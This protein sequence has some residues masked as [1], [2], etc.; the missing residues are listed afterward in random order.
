MGCH[1]KEKRPEENDIYIFFHKMEKDVDLNYTIEDYDKNYDQISKLSKNKFKK[2]EK[3]QSVRI[4]FVNEIM[5]N[6]SKLDISEREDR[7]TRK[8]LFY[9]LVLTMTLNNFLK[10]NEYNSYIKSN[11]D[12]QQS[13]L[14]L[15][16]QT[17]EQ[18]F[19]NIQNLKLIIYYIAKMFVLLFKEMHDI[20][21]Y[22]NIEKYIKQLNTI[23]EKE[24]NLEEKEIY[25]FIKVNLSCLGEYFFSNY[26]ETNLK[27]SSITIITNYFV[28]VLFDKTPFIAQNYDTYKKEIFSEH[29][30]FNINQLLNDKKKYYDKDNR[31]RT[32]A[33]INNINILIKSNKISNKTEEKKF[34]ENFEF[35]E[36]SSKF[37][38]DQNFIDLNQIN[39]SFYYFFKSVIRDIS[40]GKKIF[41]IFY[42]L[43]KDF[44]TKKSNDMRVNKNIPDFNKANEILLILF[45]V[46]CKIYCDNVIIYSFLEFESEKIKEA[47]KNKDFFYNFVMIFFEL[48]KDDKD[49]YDRNLK[50]L[51]QIFIVELGN[52]IEDEDF[53][54]DTILNYSKILNMN[55]SRLGLFLSFLSNLISM[56]KDAQDDNLT[57]DALTFICEIF[58]KLNNNNNRKSR[59]IIED[60]QSN[61]S[62]VKNKTKKYKLNKQE[63][64]N[65]LN[66]CDFNK[67][68][69]KGKNDYIKKK[70]NDFF[71]ANLNFF[72]KF[73]TFADNNFIFTDVYEDMTSRK[74]FYQKIITVITKLELMYINEI[75]I[76][77][78]SSLLKVLINI[79]K[80]NTNNYFIDFEIIYKCLNMNIYQI[81]KINE[82]QISITCFKLFYSISIFIITQ[83]KKIFRIPSSIQK[84]HNDII[85][86]ISKINRNYYKY[87]NDIDIYDYNT[88]SF[89]DNIDLFYQ[90]IIEDFSNKK[91]DDLL[92]SKKDF[93]KLIDLIH[94]K[95]FGK[96]SPLIVYFK[97]QGN[98]LDDYEIEY[99]SDK[100]KGGRGEEDNLI[101]NLQNIDDN[102]EDFDNMIIEEERNANDSVTI[103]VNESNSNILDL[104]LRE[105]RNNSE[106]D[107]DDDESQSISKYSD[108]YSQNIN[109]PEN[110]EDAISSS[111]YKMQSKKSI[112]LNSF[113]EENSVN[114]L[115][116]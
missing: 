5:K 15:A 47:Y 29:Y 107:D 14:T 50:L 13:L 63:F 116:V 6:L 61:N 72:V 27:L 16:V 85:Q 81:S 58:G 46:K 36:I 101:D 11:N 106:E 84:L 112:I 98:Q 1:Q 90:K 99:K 35:D 70:S 79:I 34:D 115:K 52:A 21:Q 75:Y 37:R 51:S 89:N 94:F 73:L 96:N 60:I 55:D 83:I 64:E 45:F 4:G 56:L 92:L 65:I 49:I 91:S 86:E 76:N 41:E 95:L 103:T 62:S 39:E 110:D 82:E 30:L 68:D 53:L 74:N 109:I 71:I 59:I 105:K 67:K 12:L 100:N 23:T 42:Y 20:D 22:I 44:I 8:F 43:I 113:F 2:L 48:F 17:L 25:P 66:F 80:K 3:K 102:F 104:S 40:G 9:A 87:L 108:T 111:K 38:K 19:E 26:K 54:I 114:N 28:I 69:K 31:K 24:N 7:I 33:T 32:L 93:K 10:E 57:K 78:L 18:K 97:S 88:N 77:E